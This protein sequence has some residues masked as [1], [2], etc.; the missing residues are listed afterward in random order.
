MSRPSIGVQMDPKARQA[1]KLARE[2]KRVSQEAASR[3]LGVSLSLFRAW[4]WGQRNPSP[5]HLAA[6]EAMLK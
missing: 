4:E 1:L 3:V 2:T 6:W 5:E